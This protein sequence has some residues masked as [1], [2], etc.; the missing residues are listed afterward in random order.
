MTSK[1]NPTGIYGQTFIEKKLEHFNVEFGIDVF[2]SF[3]P[4]YIKRNFEH[5]L[6]EAL[7]EQAEEIYSEL[8]KISTTRHNKGWVML[9]SAWKLI[10]EGYLK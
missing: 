8:S 4:K 1:T 6:V 5:F 2:E 10:K 7:T 9:E 3:D